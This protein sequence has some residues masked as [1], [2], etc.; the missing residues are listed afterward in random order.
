MGTGGLDALDPI[1]VD[2]KCDPSK[3]RKK[4]GIYVATFAEQEASVWVE[5]L[6]LISKVIGGLA[7]GML[8]AIGVI[9]LRKHLNAP[10]LNQVQN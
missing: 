10:A 7:A 8:I 5:M 4:F 3:V 6:R 2:W 9:L 1:S